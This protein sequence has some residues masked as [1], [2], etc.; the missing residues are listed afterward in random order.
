MKKKILVI[1]IYSHPEYYPPTLNALEYLSVIYDHIYVVHRNITG[2]DWQYPANVTLLCAGTPVHV[3]KAEALSLRFKLRKF[4]RF[5]KL[6]HKTI[7]RHR[8]HTI[9]IYDSMALLGLRF[10]FPLIKKPACLWYHN[11]DVSEP[12][13]LR[14]NSLAWLAWKSETWAFPKL[15]IFSLPAMERQEYFPMQRLRGKFCFLPN[16][17][18]QRVYESVPEN[19]GKSNDVFSLL[20]QG[21]IGPEHGL[22]EIIP[23]L[24]APV[25]GKTLQMVLKGF[26]ADEYLDELRGIAVQ[27]GVTEQLIYV[28]PGGYRGVIENA[29]RCHAGIGIHKKQDAMNKTLGTASNK[30]YEYAAAGMPALVYDNNHF[31]KT[32]GGR[33]WIIFT[34]T[35][36]NSLKAALEQLIAGGHTLGRQALADFQNGLCF[37]AYFLPLTEYLKTIK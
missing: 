25:M 3:R 36:E 7:R 34:D 24:A 17:P 1:G 2:F 22:E 33:N 16:F 19:G 9:L 23:F 28:P 37:E 12:Q 10:L 29:R 20:Y 26:I 5:T 21:S 31:R 32:L 27:Y 14:K 11:H 8:P 4:F 18:S 15:D 35:S 30:I 13:Y 6:L